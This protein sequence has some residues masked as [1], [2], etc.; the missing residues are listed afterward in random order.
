M[1]VSRL[2]LRVRTVEARSHLE[3]GG[4]PVAL[5]MAD[6]TDAL[7]VKYVST[8]KAN[9]A[10]V[11]RYIYGARDPKSSALYYSTIGVLAQNLR[12]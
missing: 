12:N 1:M 5:V 8:G 6:S 9:E 2:G 11:N 3:P 4:G 10:D 7:R